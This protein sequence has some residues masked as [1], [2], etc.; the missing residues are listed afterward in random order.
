MTSIFNTTFKGVEIA[1]ETGDITQAQYGAIVVS[2]DTSFSL[3]AGAGNAVLCVGGLAFQQNLN[4]SRFQM[5][6]GNNNILVVQAAGN[7]RANTV[8]LVALRGH[9]RPY[10]ESLY[11]DVIQEAIRLNVGTVAIPA[12][13]CGAY[14]YPL[15]AAAEHAR[16]AIQ[17]CTNFGNLT[18]ICF[19]DLSGY[20]LRE[21]RDKLSALIPHGNLPQQ[22]AGLSAA[23]NLNQPNLA[24][25]LSTYI[26]PNFVPLNQATTALAANHV[27][28]LQ[29]GNVNIPQA[30][31]P[32]TS[33]LPT[34]R[35]EAIKMKEF[36]SAIIRMHENGYSVKELQ[37][38]S[39]FL[40]LPFM[41]ILS[42][43]KK[44]A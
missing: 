24:F 42:A 29:N 19:M 26:M 11:R 28:S 43:L 1:C 5:N 33:Q 36:R 9:H 3:N 20:S 27:Y 38:F 41:M 8:I 13:G 4:Q 18:K 2:T 15:H 30:V 6:G 16:N 25:N 34:T 21:F 32:Q 22:P 7:L 12:I 17:N 31:Q 35:F 39:V 14:G 23:N 40:S 10:M 44:R 37:R